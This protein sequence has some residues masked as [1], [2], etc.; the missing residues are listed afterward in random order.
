[1]FFDIQAEPRFF[2]IPNGRVVAADKTGPNIPPAAV[3]GK[4]DDKPD[5]NDSTVAA[6]HDETAIRQ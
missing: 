5:A 2:A 1:M 4:T 3:E 6:G